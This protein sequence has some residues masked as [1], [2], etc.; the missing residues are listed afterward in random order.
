MVA[1]HPRV[2]FSSAQL[3]GI[4]C[5]SLSGLPISVTMSNSESLFQESDALVGGLHAF[6]AMIVVLRFSEQVD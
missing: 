1:H 3:K 5:S 6:L 4:V 2:Q